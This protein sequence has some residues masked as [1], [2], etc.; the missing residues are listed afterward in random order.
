MKDC[1]TKMNPIIEHF[2][3]KENKRFQTDL[4]FRLCEKVGEDDIEITTL[5]DDTFL[6]LSELSKVSEKEKLKAYYKT[7]ALLKKKTKEKFGYIEKGSLQAEYMAL[8]VG[9]GVALGAAFVTTNPAFIGIFMPIGL[10]VGLAI[11][12]KKEDEAEKQEKTY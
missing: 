1:K 8:G 5:V 11:G 10:A 3:E 9:V 4:F 6:L 7:L 2:D 12:K